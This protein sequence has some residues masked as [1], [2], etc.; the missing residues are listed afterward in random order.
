[1]E[2]YRY[3]P[4]DSGFRE[5]VNSN[6]KSKERDKA[7]DEWIKANG[8]LVSLRDYF[9]DSSRGSYRCD[10]AYQC[11]GEAEN[12][13]ERLA[14]AEI[15]FDDGLAYCDARERFPEDLCE[16]RTDWSQMESYA[17]GLY[18]FV[19]QVKREFADGTITLD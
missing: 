12:C 2:I 15:D 1:M 17:D 10:H 9:N 7:M 19:E 5:V 14:K 18:W 3:D 16:S 4:N 13:I 11:F 8:K 6:L